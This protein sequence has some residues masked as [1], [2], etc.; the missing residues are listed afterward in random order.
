MIRR[1]GD[2]A[3]HAI[4]LTDGHNQ[5]HRSE[6]DAALSSCE[7]AFQCDCRGVGTD[8]RVEE[9]RAIADSLLG[10]VDII[11]RPSDM[12]AD[13]ETMMIAAMGKAAGDVWLELWTPQGV[14][15]Q[16]VKQVAP[17]LVDLTPRR[18]P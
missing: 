4:L 6:F 7:G 15:V 14:T 17:A 12:I 1:Q 9:L 16:F 11:A 13:F 3:G 8:W 5:Q 18:K 2:T 10:T